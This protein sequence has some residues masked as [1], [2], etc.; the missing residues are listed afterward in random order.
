MLGVA[1]KEWAVVCEL[2]LEGRLALLLR[3]G[4][5]AE[6]GGPGRFELEHPRF[7]LFPSWAHQKPEM[8]EEPYR[9]RVRV[10][11]EPER[12]TFR[13]LGEASRIWRLAGRGVF[14]PGGPLD[15]LHPWTPAQI[16]MR[17]DYKP[18]NPLYLM[19]VR[20]YRL[21]AEKT[22]VYTPEYGGCRSWVPLSPAD[23][24]DDAG[25]TPVLDDAA[26]AALVARVDAALG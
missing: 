17:F 11:A 3:K 26:F 12:I 15:A 20:V 19:A 25:A 24:V 1:L 22:V 16:D 10:L 14:A 2:M 9:G 23:A 8:L 5:I 4:G 18:G 7:L 6:S 21:G 13:G